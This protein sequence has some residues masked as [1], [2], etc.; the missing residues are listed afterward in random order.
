[1]TTAQ[2]MIALSAS[3]AVAAMR[4]GRFTALAYAEALLAQC[5]AHADLNAFITLDADAVRASANAADAWRAAGHGPLVGIE[6]SVD[7]ASTV[8]SLLSSCS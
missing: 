4:E 3:E 7:R 1:M 6:I 8:L 5:A 2:T